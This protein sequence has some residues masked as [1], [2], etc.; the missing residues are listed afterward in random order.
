MLATAALGAKPYPSLRAFCDACAVIAGTHEGT[1]GSVRNVNRSNTR[2]VL[3][4]VVPPNG[5]RFKS[6]AR[7]VRTSNGVFGYA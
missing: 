1:A 5:V 6:L 4:T 3:I 7:N 2:Y